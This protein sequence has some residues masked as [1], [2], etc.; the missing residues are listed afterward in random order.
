[1]TTRTPCITLD[2]PVKIGAVLRHRAK[3]GE[4]Y[5]EHLASRGDGESGFFHG[6][7]SREELK[8]V[9]IYMMM[10]KLY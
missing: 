3:G 9:I 7:T 10:S 2:N 5:L 6:V 4:N 1:M 8:C